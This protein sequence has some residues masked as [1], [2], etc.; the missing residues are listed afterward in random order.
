MTWARTN[1]S[2]SSRFLRVRTYGS[3][4]PFPKFAEIVCDKWIRYIPCLLCLSK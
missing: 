4:T 2:I 1:W 3:W